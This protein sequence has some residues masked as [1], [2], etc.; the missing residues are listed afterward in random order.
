LIYFTHTGI[1][2]ELRLEACCPLTSLTSGDA[3]DLGGVEAVHE[4]DVDVGRLAVGVSGG[5]AFSEWDCCITR[6]AYQL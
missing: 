2:A 4:H 6:S 1:A 5:V 3:N